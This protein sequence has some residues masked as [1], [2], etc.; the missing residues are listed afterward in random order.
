MTAKSLPVLMLLVVGVTGAM[1]LRAEDPPAL[2]DALELLQNGDAK[3]AVARLEAITRKTPSSPRAWRALGTAHQQL[4]QPDQAL[5]AF[6]RA[7]S[8]EP[9]SPQTLY[10]LGSAFAMKGDIDSALKWF[11]Q[12]RDTRRFDMTQLTVDPALVRWAHDQRLLALVPKPQDFEQPFVEPVRI[13]REWRGETANDQFGWIA[14]NLGDVDGDGV[15]DV[16]TSAPTHGKAAAAAGRIYVYST[17]S[18]KL[19]WQADGPEGSELGSGVECA[20]D[21]NGDGMPDVVASGPP[22]GVAFLY[23]GRD[24]RVLRE[25]RS[26][27]ERELFGNHVAGVGDIDG[28]GSAD[29]LIGAPGKGSDDIPGRALLY[30]GKTGALISTLTGER[31]GDGFGSAVAGGHS[32]DH[33]YLVVGAP[34]AGPKRHG[35]V[36]VYD[37]TFDA[38]AFTIDADDTGRALG[39][40]FLSVVGDVDADGVADVYASDWSNTAKGYMTGRIVVHSG[41]TGALLLTLTGDTAGEG[42]GIG[43]ANAGDVDRDGHADLIVGAWQFGRGA[44]SGGRAYLFSGLDGHLL[45]TYTSRVPGETFGF[46][47]TNLGDIDGDGTTDFLITAAWS[48]V[49]GH[50]SGRV[51]VISSDLRVK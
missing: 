7:L 36:Y 2:T 8:A 33:R 16:V 9:D 39:L 3:A 20:G 42:F 10:S 21:T 47:A 5:S 28:D 22:R 4:K 37:R 44:V 24:G 12:A 51:F 40:M 11:A 17:R 48:A 23:S 49:R 35:R 27:D 19:L 50:H 14:R 32:A 43:P 41:R 15:N 6:Q 29:V 45:K 18:G 26:T 25:F 31:A 34:R 13:L 30:S 38:P 1:P 46:D